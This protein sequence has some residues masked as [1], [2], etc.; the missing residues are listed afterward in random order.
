MVN[1]TIVSKPQIT[2]PMTMITDYLIT[3]QLFIFIF[4]L[5]PSLSNLP[6]LSFSLMFLATAIGAFAGGTAHGFTQYLGDRHKI[7]WSIAIQSIGFAT[8]FFELGIVLEY[9]AGVMKNIAILIVIIQLIAYEYWILSKE[10]VKFSDVIINYGTTMV[11][12]LLYFAARYIENKDNDIQYLITAIVF[13]FVAAGIQ[14]KGFSIHKHF[15]H[16]DIY[17]IIQMF[18]F[19]YFY[20]AA[21]EFSG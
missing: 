10:E 6:R 2:E 4:W 16:N 11:I 3:L 5:R 19:Y 15:N 20:L 1:N 18:G 8:T 14:Q 13:G 12:G 21:K 9:F 17:H 7:T